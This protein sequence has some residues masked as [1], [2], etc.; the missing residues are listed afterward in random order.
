L[1]D[2]IPSKYLDESMAAL[3]LPKQGMA[4]QGRSIAQHVLPLLLV[5]IW[6][7]ASAVFSVATKTILIPEA[8][9]S[10]ALFLS[11]L[12]LLFCSAIYLV[13]GA[14]RGF[15]GLQS[16][17]QS[18]WSIGML[19]GMGNSSTYILLLLSTVSK[20]QILKGMEPLFLVTAVALL[21]AQSKEAFSMRK[22]VGFLVAVSGML[23]S[24]WQ[25]QGYIA[26]IPIIA[27]VVAN[28]CFAL[29]TVLT[30]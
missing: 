11:T 24:T 14:S 15:R 13:F 16:E 26:Q 4:E 18:C 8:P 7:G 10:H 25:P 2:D 28:T 1:E 29:R 22:V 30:K 3:D 21:P 23:L 6:W 12:H 19:L 20:T 5:L 17:L 9:I 27:S